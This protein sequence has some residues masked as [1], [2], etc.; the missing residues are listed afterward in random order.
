M[1][2]VFDERSINWT[3]N[4]DYNIMYLRAKQQYFTDVLRAR[5]HISLCEILDDTGIVLDKPLSL[6]ELYGHFWSYGKGDRFVDLGIP[7]EFMAMD[8]KV[9]RLD[10]DGYKSSTVAASCISIAIRRSGYPIKSFKRGEFVYLS[11]V[12]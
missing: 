3:D 4:A 7:K 10:V 12:S 11:K 6:A 2:A 9:V 8:A 5:G 1:K